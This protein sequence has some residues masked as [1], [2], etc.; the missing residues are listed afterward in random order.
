M[1]RS[2]ATAAV[3]LA[4]MCASVSTALAQSS[5]VDAYSGS[6]GEEQSAVAQDT[7][8]RLPFTG[9]DLIFVGVAGLGLLGGGV[10]LRRIVG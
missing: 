5:S 1:R 9:Q 3:T 7:G 8:A 2:T 6:G 4:L 10:V